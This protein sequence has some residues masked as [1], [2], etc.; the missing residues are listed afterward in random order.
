MIE[1]QH[2]SSLSDTTDF[3][4]ETLH[5]HLTKGERILWLTSGGSN[6]AVSADIARRLE[7]Q[8][9]SRLYISLVDERFGPVGHADENWQQL[10]NTG[11]EP[12]GAHL[13][14]PLSGQNRQATTSQFSDWLK[15]QLKSSDFSVGLFGIGADGHTAGIKPHSK[16]VSSIEWATSYTW[17][18]FERITM[19]PMAITT[20]DLAVTQ[21]SG[22]D[23]HNTIK[24]LLAY[25]VSI[26]DQ[27][28]QVLK[29]VKR[30]ILFT[31][32]KEEKS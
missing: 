25:D 16:S 6:I 29:Q 28:A 7:G 27:P 13:Y 8:D 22:Q 32:Y 5:Q 20:L 1:Y 2:V 12:T 15:E 31:D 19:T 11:F 21:A 30:S 9:L 23:K 14:R 26:D 4:V 18:D 17:N 10:L 24:Q 3:M